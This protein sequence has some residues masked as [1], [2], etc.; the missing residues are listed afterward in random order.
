MNIAELE[1]A[2]LELLP[3]DRARLAEKLLESL[4]DASHGKQLT[5]TDESQGKDVTWN[6]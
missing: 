3:K 5:W 4:E 1:T 6:S 2:A